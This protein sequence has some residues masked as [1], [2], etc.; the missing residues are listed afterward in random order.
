M[1]DNNSRQPAS[2]HL[3]W[4]DAMRF[5]AAFLVMFCHS[6]NDFFMNYDKLP[7]DEQGPVAFVFYVL[8]RLGPEAVFVFFI[9]SGFLVGGIGIERIFRGTFRLGDYAVNRTVRIGLPLVA[10]IVLYGIVTL[11]TPSQWNWLT[12]LG[13]L[14]SLQCIL[15][16]SLVSPFWSLSYEV[17]FYVVLFALALAFSNKYKVWGFLLFVL[18]C[19]VYT[20]MNPLYLLYWLMGAVAWL[21]RPKRPSRRILVLSLVM[22]VATLGLSQ[23]TSESHAMP[24]NIGM[25]RTVA[26]VLMCFSFA[27]LTQQ[28]VLFS[29]SFV[30]GRLNVTWKTE[31]L[32]SRL[33]DFSYTLY[34]THRIVFLVVFEYIFEKYQGTLCP[35]DLL[36]YSLLVIA[37]LV[38]AWLISL[39][40]EKHTAPVR[41]WIKARLFRRLPA[42]EVPH[43]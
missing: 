23:M 5:I 1:T 21:C 27:L 25:S 32:F 18:C 13:N 15:C 26:T 40:S 24:M 36:H 10:A 17:W 9:I 20:R 3:P 19:L 16:D 30:P 35:R 41:R 43:R 11:V 6:K 8:T 38:I 37:T 28:I 33:A 2:T 7:A 31:R 39:V 34:L 22:T 12:A 42:A 29:P 14:L 4:I